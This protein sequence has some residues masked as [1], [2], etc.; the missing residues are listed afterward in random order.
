LGY[1]MGHKKLALTLA[2]AD[3]PVHLDTAMALAAVSTYRNTYSNIPELWQSLEEAVRRFVLPGDAIHAG[4][5][6]R[7]AHERIILP[8]DMP[9]IYKDIRIIGDGQLAYGV[10]ETRYLWGG[11]IT[12]N[13]VQALARII[14]TRAE[15]R[16]ARAGL[17]AVH[18][19]HD[20]LIFCV[21]IEHV[22][23]CEKVIARVM[24]DPVP[25][26]PDLPIAVEVHHG[27][28]YGDCK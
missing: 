27:P 12:E 1:G 26:L 16:L 14:A 6:L 19:A 2:T 10:G 18:Q 9:I 3:T 11:S 8:N 5:V 7:Y 23:A 20:E 15:L 25:W 17:R 24:T 4:K 28:T 21:P 13:V 22:D